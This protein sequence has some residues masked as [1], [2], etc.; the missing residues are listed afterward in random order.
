MGDLT[1]LMDNQAATRTMY[2]RAFGRD[3]LEALAARQGLVPVSSVTKKA[4]DLLVCA[5]LATSSGKAKKARQ[6]G[7][8]M[9][10]VEEFLREAL[11]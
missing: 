1:P 2:G 3:E 5:D 8:A 7:I 10:S 6:Y 9:M 4:C 11:R